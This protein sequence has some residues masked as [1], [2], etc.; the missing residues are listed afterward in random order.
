MGLQSFDVVTAVRANYRHSK[1]CE[2]VKTILKKNEDPYIALLNYRATP[3][4]NGYSNAELSICRRLSTTLPAAPHTLVPRSPRDI[5]QNEVDYRQNMKAN[6]DSRHGARELPPLKPGDDVAINDTK[7]EG[8]VV[9]RTEYAP[10]LHVIATP[11]GKVRCIRRPL[12]MLPTDSTQTTTT[13]STNDT[14]APTLPS[15]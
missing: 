3:L 13:P 1:C 5:G 15:T 10:N 4:L 6:Y 2:V 7:Q 9:Q 11:T 14:V 12:N 8:L